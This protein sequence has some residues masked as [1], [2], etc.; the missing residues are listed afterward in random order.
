MCDGGDAGGGGGC[1]CG[2]QIVSAALAC[3]SLVS[4]VRESG[5]GA[6]CVCAA[7]GCA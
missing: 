7:G 1:V 3:A 2:A 6:W 5:E 4:C